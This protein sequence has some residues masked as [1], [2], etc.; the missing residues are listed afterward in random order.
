MIDTHTQYIKAMATSRKPPS[1]GY[2]GYG[3]RN[4]SPEES[5]LKA[6]WAAIADKKDGE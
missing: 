2:T 4:D 1:G 3:S 5:R 6:E